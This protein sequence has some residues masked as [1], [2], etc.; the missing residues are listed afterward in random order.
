MNVLA[1][2]LP[3]AKRSVGPLA[4]TA[5]LLA[6]VSCAPLRPP[7]DPGVFAERHRERPW[8]T[9]EGLSEGRSIFRASCAA[10]HG[11]PSPDDHPAE[12]W[13]KIVADMAPRSDL[14]TTRA[15]KLLDW[16]LLG[17]SLMAISNPI[18]EENRP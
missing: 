11:L 9:M 5:M 2:F 1:S 18:P 17:D 4:G 3:H 10:C 8:A 7:L 15:R 16:I 14:D 13:P 6:F 12:A